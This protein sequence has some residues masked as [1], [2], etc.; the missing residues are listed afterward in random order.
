[1]FEDRFDSW[2]E[3]ISKIS[4]EEWRGS[5]NWLF[6]GAIAISCSQILRYNRLLPN[7]KHEIQMENTKLVHN[8][9]NLEYNINSPI[10]ETT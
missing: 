9:L 10:L 5:R 6:F 3:T 1:M 2:F 8:C 4:S 7:I